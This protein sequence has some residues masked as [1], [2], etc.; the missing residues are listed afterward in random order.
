[1][2]LLSLPSRLDERH[3][4]IYLAAGVLAA[5]KAVTLRNDRTR[6]RRELRE[7]ALFLGLGLVLRTYHRRSGSEADDAEDETAEAAGTEPAV[8]DADVAEASADESSSRL[9]RTARRIVPR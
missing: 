5:L 8:E 4:T 9:E 7:A 6:F 2:S 1:M 3:A